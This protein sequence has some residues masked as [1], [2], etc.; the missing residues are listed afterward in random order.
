MRVLKWIIDRALGRVG[1]QETLLGWVPRAGDL[2]LSGLNVP[3]E[4]VEEAT[5]IDHA[6]WKAEL[7]SEE[8]WFKKLNRTLPKALELQRQLLMAKLQ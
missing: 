2:D 8:E 6:A 7:E 3:N 1:G 5:S 4:D